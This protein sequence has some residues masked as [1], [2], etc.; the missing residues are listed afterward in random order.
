MNL[1][2]LSPAYSPWSSG[3]QGVYGLS[4]GEGKQ[5]ALQ[6]VSSAG[7]IAAGT[8]PLWT[9]AAW[10]IPVIGAG[11]AGVAL[12]LTAWFNRKGPRQKIQTTEIVNEL[13]PMLLNNLNAYKAGPHTVSSQ[14]QALAVFDAVWDAMVEAC[15][16]E[17]YGEP[18][19][20]CVSDRQAGACEWKD[21]G[22]CWN[23]FVGYRDPIANDPNVV[24]DPTVSETV[25]E[26]VSQLTASIPGGSSTL[27]L[28]GAGLLLLLAF[29]G[30][31]K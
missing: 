22:E 27:L 29:T 24:P 6:T 19:K 11:V 14:A 2:P 17:Q 16:Q 18:G 1:Q 10:A 7:A 12:A 25:S 31:S 8:A 15:R 23:W 21:A 4:T 26:S 13:E 9:Q 28:A 30:G 20:R 5:I 3:L